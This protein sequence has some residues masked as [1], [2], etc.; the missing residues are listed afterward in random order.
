MAGGVSVIKDDC[1]VA[2]LSFRERHAITRHYRKFTLEVCVQPAN[3]KQR[4]CC[5]RNLSNRADQ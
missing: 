2:S 5:R 4:I 3:E 1:L